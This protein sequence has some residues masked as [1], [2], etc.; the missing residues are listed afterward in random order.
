MGCIPVIFENN[1]SIY[2]NIFKN[3]IDI[4]E[5][6]IIIKNNEILNIENIL[7]NIILNKN[8]NKFS[9]SIQKMVYNINKIKHLLLYPDN[10]NIYIEYIINNITNIIN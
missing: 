5:I 8:N 2:E 3:I 4:N 9:I 6:C 7:T 10:N 1:Y